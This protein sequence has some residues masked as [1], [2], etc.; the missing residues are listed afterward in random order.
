MKNYIKSS[1]RLALTILLALQQIAISPCL[2]EDSASTDTSVTLE[3][4]AKEVVLSSKLIKYVKGYEIFL[5]NK[6]P[7]PINID[8]IKVQNGMSGDSVYN[9]YKNS[10]SSVAVMWTGAILLSWLFLIPPLLAAIATPFVVVKNNKVN[11]LSWKEGGEFPN[12][13]EQ[14]TLKPDEQISYKTMLNPSD[15]LSVEIAY[16]DTVTSE[17]KRY[18][19]DF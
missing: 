3:L 6:G 1:L 12:H 16:T 17:S 13:L 8:D 2:A 7:N 18:K 4:T 9:Q 15:P 14:T 5:H 19:M 10:N 11:K